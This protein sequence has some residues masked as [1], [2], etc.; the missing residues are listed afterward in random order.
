MF[1]SLMDYLLIAPLEPRFDNSVVKT[2]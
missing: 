1:V 2:Y